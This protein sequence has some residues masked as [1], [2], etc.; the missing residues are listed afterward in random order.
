MVCATAGTEKSVATTSSPTAPIFQTNV[1]KSSKLSVPPTL[2]I[3]GIQLRLF[4]IGINP[5]RVYLWT[6]IW[7]VIAENL[8]FRRYVRPYHACCADPFQLVFR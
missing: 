1:L 8:Y 2:A 4:Q 5:N 7:V 3:Y 6:N